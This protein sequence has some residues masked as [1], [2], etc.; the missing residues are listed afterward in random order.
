MHLLSLQMPSTSPQH[1]VQRLRLLTILVRPLRS[2]VRYVE[3]ESP[4]MLKTLVLSEHG[5]DYGDDGGGTVSSHTRVSLS[6]VRLMKRGGDWVLAN[7]SQPHPPISLEDRAVLTVQAFRLFGGVLAEWV[8]E[9]QRWVVSVRV[10]GQANRTNS[11]VDG[12]HAGST[13]TSAL[14]TDP[15]VREWLKLG[16]ARPV[17]AAE[18]AVDSLVAMYNEPLEVVQKRMPSSAANDPAAVAEVSVMCLPSSPRR[19]HVIAS[20]TQD[21]HTHTHTHTHSDSVSVN[22]NAF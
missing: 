6:G 19:H 13:N 9:Q 2:F 21:T 1:Q 10:R 3:I 16:G 8:V 4:A 14:A 15:V 18:A 20:H 22:D 5:A 17:A 12:T 7:G 11:S